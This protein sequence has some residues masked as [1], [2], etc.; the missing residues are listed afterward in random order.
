MHLKKFSEI[1]FILF[2]KTNW[3]G[4][5]TRPK[6]PFCIWRNSVFFK[7]I[8]RKGQSGKYFNSTRR[9]R[10][11]L[12]NT[13]VTLKF[14]E[15]LTW[16]SWLFWLI[17]TC[18]ILSSKQKVS[19]ILMLFPTLSTTSGA[20]IPCQNEW[21]DFCT[22]TWKRLWSLSL[23]QSYPTAS[24][25]PSHIVNGHQIIF[26]LSFHCP[27]TTSTKIMNF[28]NSLLVPTTF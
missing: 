15:I 1:L 13:I 27:S 9:R 28:V 22:I 7:D 14:R 2:F 3:S 24:M 20:P 4:G 8:Q 18:I 25:S 11:H 16:K 6:N 10:V 21:L 19:S 12:W 26:Q 23:K 5:S 17:E